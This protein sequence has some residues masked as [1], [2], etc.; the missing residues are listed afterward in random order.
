MM[1]SSLYN[2][3]RK[4][5]RPQTEM[6]VCIKVVPVQSPA[7]SC[8][9]SPDVSCSAQTSSAGSLWSSASC[10]APAPRP[11]TCTPH[12]SRQSFSV[13]VFS[14]NTGTA[15]DNVVQKEV[16]QTDRSNCKKYCELGLCTSEIIH[17]NG[18]IFLSRRIFSTHK[19]TLNPPIYLKKLKIS[20]FGDAWFSLDS[21]N[22]L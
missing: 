19:V 21:N 8:Q 16:Y 22:I 9:R 20:I 15:A 13:I 14:R 4:P 7:A 3:H 18:L 5:Q 10:S 12:I 6:L 11:D 1:V 2:R 17:L